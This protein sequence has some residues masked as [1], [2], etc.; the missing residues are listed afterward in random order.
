VDAD[1][2][3][4][5]AEAVRHAYARHAPLAIYGGNSKAF[6]G[7]EVNGDPLDVTMHRGIV[8]Y[9]PTELVI[10]ARAGTRLREIEARLR[11]QEQMLA[12]EPPHFGDRATL[13][14]C[15][16]AGLS[17]PRR[18]YAGS[19]RDSLLGVEII[20]GTGERLKFGGE[21]MK[22]VAGYDLSRLMAGAL[23]TL[24]VLLQASFKVLPSPEREIT[25]RRELSEA[26]AIEWGRQPMPVSATWHDGDCLYT[27]LAGGH[28]ATDTAA[29][30]LGGE[31]LVDADALWHGVREQTA[32]FFA[33]DTPL[34]RLSVPPAM[35]PLNLTGQCALEWH[36]ALR[37][38]KT[39]APPKE[40]R[41][42]VIA[43]GGHAIQFRG[44]DRAGEVF[45]PLP[46]ALMTMHTNL[47]Q[48]FD[49]A[50]ILNSGRMYPGL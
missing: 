7:R 44:G 18:P 11:E 22:N 15:V 37:W 16:A 20:N 45:Q 42:R 47:K 6:Y 19:L 21:V 31:P 40:I 43:A 49:P 25:L 32:P 9:E 17:G 3:E 27:R 26:R 35:P 50:G 14:G 10:T 8:N 36:G 38:L 46:D 29:R 28:S 39:N 24:G 12:F 4:A 2:G 23:G 48:A 5:L 13:G 34:W 33:G 41:A 1:Q 30:Q